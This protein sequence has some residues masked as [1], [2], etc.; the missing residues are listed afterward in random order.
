M[1][2]DSMRHYE[3]V[4][5][6]HPEQSER[7]GEMV[8]RYTTLIQEQGGV[9]HRLEDWGRRTLAYP[10]QK[11]RKAHY[12]L[13]NFECDSATLDVLEE[14]LRFNEAVLRRMVL[15]RPKAETDPSPLE[16]SRDQEGRERYRDD[17]DEYGSEE[18]TRPYRATREEAPEPQPE[19]Q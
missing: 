10:I 17:G 13:I 5:L 8:E 4:I 1:G 9:V 12:V 3:L 6:F 2:L 18:E 7:V 15:A 14:R 16:R 19:I 11:L